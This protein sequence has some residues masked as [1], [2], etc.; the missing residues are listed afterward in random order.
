MSKQEPTA[1]Q[2]TLVT[3]QFGTTA[4]AY[5]TSGVHAAG[6]DL[7]RLA[8]LADALRPARVLDL[9]CGAGHVSYALARGGAG[10]VVAYDLAQEMLTVV[11]TEAA[12]R[13][14]PN[15]LTERGPAER[16][17]FAAASFDWVVSRYS[18][19]HW[20][21]LPGALAEGA[22]VC[23]PGG[24]C[25]VIDV[26]APESPLL[27]TVLQTVEILRDPSHVR[28]HRVSEWRR[29]LAEVGF[30]VTE[31]ESWKL[32]MGFDSWVGR[33]GASAER[34][35]ALHMVFAGLP[36]EARQYFSVA[37]DHSFSIDSAWIE[38]FKPT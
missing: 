29:L 18:A 38:G 2:H 27:D 15:I 16:L 19:H 10:E 21:D 26:V 34:I 28:D 13:G 22:R 24:R 35:G 37:A 14:H 20:L 8:R 3:R 11:A 23:K 31:S 9:G 32:P 30:T 17:P 7:E 1:G 4:A 6:A 12:R 5:L 36:A 33:M 25:I